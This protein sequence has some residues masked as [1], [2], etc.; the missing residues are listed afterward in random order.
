[1]AT[2]GDGYWRGMLKD[3]YQLFNALTG[4]W[5]KYDGSGN[6]LKSKFSEGP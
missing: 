3:R 2:K 5:D 6:F 1:M 4:L